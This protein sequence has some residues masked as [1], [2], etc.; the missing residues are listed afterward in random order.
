MKTCAPVIGPG[1]LRRLLECLTLFFT[2][3]VLDD[4]FSQD[5]VR[6][7]A[8]RF[9]KLLNPLLQFVVELDGCRGRGFSHESVSVVKGNTWHYFTRILVDRSMAYGGAVDIRL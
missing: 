9:G 6:T 2:V 3:D 4:G 7:A 8:S 1:V 5:S